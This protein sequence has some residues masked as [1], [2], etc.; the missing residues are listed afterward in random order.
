MNTWISLT[1]ARGIAILV[2]LLAGL[3]AASAAEGM[4]LGDVMEMSRRK[5]DGSLLSWELTSPFAA[6]AD[7]VVP[8]LI[9]W[10]DSTPPASELPPGP[11]L[12]DFK[13]EHPE[14]G[15]IRSALEAVGS[16]VEVVESGRPGLVAWIRTTDAVVV[17]R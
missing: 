11:R 5:P 17:L 3:A 8:F 2:V 14:P 4:E 7:G 12:V 10:L 6:R 16:S 9:D 13:I 1:R 15:P